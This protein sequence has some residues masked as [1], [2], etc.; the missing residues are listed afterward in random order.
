MINLSE[1]RPWLPLLVSG[2]VKENDQFPEHTIPVSV[3]MTEERVRVSLT[4]E[5]KQGDRDGYRIVELDVL[6]CED[7]E[8][9]FR[10]TITVTDGENTFV[11][12]VRWR[13]TEGQL[14]YFIDTN[15]TVSSRKAEVRYTETGL[16][17]CENCFASK[18]IAEHVAAAFRHALTTCRIVL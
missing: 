5:V 15:M 3:Q 7:E 12:G 2:Q 6:G 10:N 4:S 11:L 16:F 13:P 9:T 1:N 18:A 14:Y 8:H 17:E